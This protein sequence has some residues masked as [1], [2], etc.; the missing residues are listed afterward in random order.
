[1]FKI[2]PNHQ[3][4]LMKNYDCL[5]KNKQNHIL[6][7]RFNFVKK[8]NVQTC[9]I[10][11]NNCNKKRNSNSRNRERINFGSLPIPTFDQFLCPTS[12]NVGASKLQMEGWVSLPPASQN[13]PKTPP[14][15]SLWKN[16]KK[17][18]SMYANTDAKCSK[19]LNSKT[20]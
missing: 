16:P 15:K 14:F 11:P 17:P 13:D 6:M 10:C 7:Q 4:Q 9:W 19:P 3:F 5:P 20:L 18:N 12:Q 8:L 2:T 1:M